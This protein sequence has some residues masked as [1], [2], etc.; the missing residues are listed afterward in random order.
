MCLRKSAC[1]TEKHAWNDH[2]EP[3]KALGSQLAEGL[4][5]WLI[6]Y[7]SSVHK[8]LQ[9]FLTAAAVVGLL[10]VDEGSYIATTAVI[11]LCFIWLCWLLLVQT[12]LA[13]MP[14][15][16]WLTHG[17][18]KALCL[19]ITNLQPI[20]QQVFIIICR[21]GSVL[22]HYGLHRRNSS[23]NRP[24]ILLCWHKQWS[25]LPW[26]NY[27]HP[28]YWYV[29]YNLKGAGGYATLY[30]PSCCYIS[31]PLITRVIEGSF[32]YVS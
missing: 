15:V 8:M 29:L 24:K 25:L 14:K 21:F 7:L 16:W 5:L 3:I 13:T 20:Y 19:S 12:Y 10:F 28:V 27:M 1:I 30:C 32:Y 11:V 26:W 4:S 6:A 18:R 2:W 9:I 17:G 22:H 23:S 31:N